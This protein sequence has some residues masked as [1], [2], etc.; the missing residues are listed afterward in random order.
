MVLKC[1]LMCPCF[2]RSGARAGGEREGIYLVKRERSRMSLIVFSRLSPEHLIT[3][4][5]F[6]IFFLRIGHSAACF[7]RSFKISFDV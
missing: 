4:F 2:P 1:R 5:F 7:S 6:F 3:Y